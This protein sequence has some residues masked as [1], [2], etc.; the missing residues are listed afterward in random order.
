M[1]RAAAILGSPRRRF[2]LPGSRGVGPAELRGGER[3]GGEPGGR[4]LRGGGSDTMGQCGITSSK[5]VLVFLNLIFWVSP[6]GPGKM[7]APQQCG[8]G[9][10][11]AE[12]GAGPGAEGGA[13][14]AASP[15]SRP[16]C[17]LGAPRRSRFFFTVF[18][19]SLNVFSL[20][21]IVFSWEAAS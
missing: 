1:T 3:S 19:F 13:G 5:T 17:R 14:R 9:R 15:P 4:R 12:R 7:G 16:C 11:W 18:H 10:A 20:K 8:V 6:E 2:W 21:V